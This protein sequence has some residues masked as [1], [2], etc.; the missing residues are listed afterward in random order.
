M[1]KHVEKLSLVAFG[2]DD[3]IKLGVVCPNDEYISDGKI[4]A[5]LVD[6]GDIK[7]LELVL[8][9]AYANSD[10]KASCSCFTRAASSSAAGGEG[11]RSS[12]CIV[13]PAIAL[14]IL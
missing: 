2:I 6:C 14:R 8:G 4:D 1:D 3:G 10:A 11:I 5:L 9:T 7:G 12:N 13:L